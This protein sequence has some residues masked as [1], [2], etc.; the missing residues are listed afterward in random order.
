MTLLLFLLLG[1]V[2][3]Y[4]LPAD[5]STWPVN[6][7]SIAKPIGHPAPIG[8]KVCV[9]FPKGDRVTYTIRDVCPAGNWDIHVRRVDQR[10]RRDVDGA[11]V[12]LGR[13]K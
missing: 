9:H 8:S 11:R 4:D 12:T 13:C 3:A 7:R 1:H 2:T 5:Y 6:A 10:V